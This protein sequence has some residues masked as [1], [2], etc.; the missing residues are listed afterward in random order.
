MWARKGLLVII[1]EWTFSGTILVLVSSL[2]LSQERASILLLS[3]Y[4]SL[5]TV[6]KPLHSCGLTT[7]VTRQTSTS[8]F[9]ELPSEWLSVQSSLVFSPSSRQSPSPPSS[10]YS[11]ASSTPSSPTRGTCSPTST[12]SSSEL[13]SFVF[14][15]GSVCYTYKLCLED[16]NVG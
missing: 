9:V 7:A 6:F 13:P 5:V 1:R 8:G 3:Q 15:Q 11:T 12:S 4:Q 16:A 2:S 14:M 10:S